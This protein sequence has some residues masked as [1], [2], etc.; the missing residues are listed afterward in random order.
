MRQCEFI[1][2]TSTVASPRE[3]EHATFARLRSRATRARL[4]A[5]ALFIFLPFSLAVGGNGN[6]AG[7]NPKIAEDLHGL[8]SGSDKKVDVIIQF[9]HVPTAADHENVRANGGVFK[10]DLHVVKGALY[11]VP[12]NALQGLAN[13]PNIVYISPDRTVGKS[14]D[15]V[16][17]VTNADLA[18]SSGLD[19]TGI[20]VA[21]VDSGVD[22]IPDLNTADQ[23]ASR[24]VYSE[25]FVTGDLTT[26]DA[27]GHGTHV[28]GIVA[29]NAYA[30]TTAYYK[31]I[32]KGIA[33]NAQI[34]NLRALNQNGSGTDS[35]VIS[36]IQR[37]IQL[38]ST[39]NIRVL[40]LSLGR[41]VFESYTLDPICQAVEAA[42]QSGIVVVVAAGNSGR[43]NS[44]GTHGYGTIAVPGNDPYVIT[45]GASN[46]HHSFSQAAQTVASF[47]SKGPTLIDHVV[48]PDLLA[49]G[50]QIVSALAPGSYIPT[51]YP[52]FDVYPCDPTLLNCNSTEGP[53]SYLRLSGTSMATPAV[54]AAVAVLLEQN[55]QLTPDQ[56]KARLMKSAY[57]GYAQ[58]S[59]AEDDWG[60]LYSLQADIF[61]VG[62]GYLDVKAALLNTDLAPATFGSAKSP[63]VGYDPTTNTTYLITDSTEI[64]NSSVVWGTSLVW[65]TAV[66]LDPV[67]GLSVV[68]GSSV[69]WGT[70]CNTQ[71]LSLIWGTSVIWG[72]NT[73]S[74]MSDGDDGDLEVVP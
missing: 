64:W 23:T 2:D 4:L 68:W 28:A 5:L 41:G 27:Y 9:N 30:S 46:M 74:A 22:Q 29:G 52:K 48:K 1:R 33:P 19:G 47:S 17:M 36:A 69:I 12:V 72:T 53:A 10:K 35:T 61:A 26:A 70:S 71:G 16:D 55:P 44:Q 73:F 65:G 3:A 6:G 59:G 39:Y 50:N 34:I 45:V 8:N 42:W 7:S 49:P 43:D 38:Q 21:V 51:Y 14:L 18:W 37:A 15:H 40:N 13:N 25:S 57:K 31:G 11:T 63:Q 20:G 67:S 62:A 58:Y 24:L 66:A 32:Y 60:N 56:V 54:S